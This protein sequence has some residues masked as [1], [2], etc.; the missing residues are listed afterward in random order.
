MYL[1]GSFMYFRGSFKQP[2]ESSGRLQG[3]GN[4]PGA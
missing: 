1:G 3:P 4:T 2:R